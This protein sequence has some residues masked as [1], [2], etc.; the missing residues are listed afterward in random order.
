MTSLDRTMRRNPAMRPAGRGLMRAVVLAIATAAGLPAPAVAQDD[1][2]SLSAQVQRLQREIATMQFRLFSGN[3]VTVPSPG[4]G[5]GST[6]GGDVATAQLSVRLAELEGSLQQVTGQLEQTNFRIEQLARQLGEMD[7]RLKKRLADMDKAITSLRRQASRQAAGSAGDQTLQ[8]PSG[9]G[10][11]AA[12]GG[13]P[14]VGGTPSISTPDP[15]GAVEQAAPETPAVDPRTVLPEGDAQV[16]YNH[17]FRLLRQGDY[18]EAERALQAFLQVHPESALSAN[19]M[20]WLGETHYVRNDYVVAARIFSETY[21]TFPAGPKAADSLLKL[22]MAL[23]NLGE[24]GTACTTFQE[25][26][27]RFPNAPSNIKLLAD[28]ER[29]RAGCR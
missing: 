17:A 28:R 4:G 20:Y 21:Q 24:Q 22:G 26:S 19:A 11:R 10:D 1:V 12:T 8:P 7:D 3:G 16:Q 5:P 14:P 23:N 18:T 25:L 13:T 9:T 2:Q 15:A 29:Q 6:T 27:R